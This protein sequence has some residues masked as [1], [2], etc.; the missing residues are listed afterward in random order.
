MGKLFRTPEGFLDLTGENVG[1]RYPPNIAQTA[2]P[3]IDMTQLLLGR[4]L[5]V[6]TVTSL[7]STFGSVEEL[8][9]PENEIW[10]L[11]SISSSV[12]MA[13]ITSQV[14]MI[15]YLSNLPESTTPADESI[16]LS[17]PLD[18]NGAAAV[19]SLVKSRVFATPFVLTP[20]C[21]IGWAVVDSDN[22]VAP[23]N[24]KASVYKLT[25]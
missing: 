7:D 15:A 16:I 23:W 4:T 24:G 11:M 8:T 13:G 20:G 10:L 19:H 9:V 17:G 3:I 22:A 1:G 21:I 2:A 5:A 12:L 6:E 14:N 25:V 18:A